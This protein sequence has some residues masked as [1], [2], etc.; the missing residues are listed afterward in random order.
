M[1]KIDNADLP[2]YKELTDFLEEN[3]WD[4]SSLTEFMGDIN[5]LKVP[6]VGDH[7]LHG[8]FLGCFVIEVKEGYAILPYTE[9]LL[10]NGWEQINQKQCHMANE[11]DLS[12]VLRAIEYH[13][14]SIIDM[15]E[16]ICEVGF[17]S[18][19]ELPRS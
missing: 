15:K 5:Y 10:G 7:Y 11:H 4:E 2:S 6:Y 14:Q 12:Y 17:R 13:A 9:V 8:E 18:K 16:F 19:Q 3:G 1:S